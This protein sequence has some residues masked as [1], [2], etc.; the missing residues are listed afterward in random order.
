MVLR[1]ITNPDDKTDGAPVIC[2]KEKKEKGEDAHISTHRK[3]KKG[4]GSGHLSLLI[5]GGGSDRSANIIRQISLILI[6]GCLVLF[7][8]TSLHLAKTGLQLKK[9]I[10][11]AASAGFKNIVNGA[12]AIEGAKF[13][14]AKELFQEAGAIFKNMEYQTWF[15]SPGMATLELKDPI[16]D[17]ANALVGTGRYLASAGETF[18]EVAQNLKSIPKNIFEANNKFYDSKTPHPSLTDELKKELPMLLLCAQDLENANGQI[19]KIPDTFVPVNLRDQFNFAKNALSTL[20]DFLGSLQSDIPAILTLLGDKEP[21]TFLILL[22]NNAEL[23]PS[24]GFIGNYMIVETNDGYVTKMEVFDVYSA[25]HNLAE[26]IE[27]PAEILPANTRWFLRDSNYSGH[28]PLSAEKAAWFLEKEGGPGV[29]TVIAV[30]QTLI[31]ELLRLT[32]PIKVPELSQ[33]LTSNNFTTV[34]SYIVESK[35][36]GREDPKAILRSFLNSFEKNIFQNID[37]G[38]LPPLLQSVIGSKHLMAYSK[39][40]DVEAFFERHGVSGEMKKLESKEDY[41]NIVHTS[42]GGNK[43]DDYIAEVIGHDTYLELD[44]SVIDQ[45]SITRAHQ[46]DGKTTQ[47]IL[48]KLTPFGFTKVDNKVWQIFGRAHNIQFL[49]I[50]VPAG[51]VMEISS[52]PSV[53][54]QFDPETGKTYFSVKMRAEIGAS[55]TIKIRYRLPFKLNLDPVDKYYLTVQ[56]QAGQSNVSIKK[57][58]LPA[59]GVINYKYFPNNGA[60]DAE[61]IWTLETELLG[62]TSF[63]SIWGK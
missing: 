14:N 12:L 10:V 51:S 44:G 35:L 21:H 55:N 8:I 29:D 57:R 18:T 45:V 19:R 1:D 26:S 30:D 59:S 58:I 24:G 33:P 50:Y 46:W 7:A 37:P 41:L 48:D 43:S 42:I 13:E 63:S 15:T 32:G 60:F 53:T 27:P 47:L 23:R 39:N 16:F 31:T 38:A 34:V 62:D 22:Q 17:S 3:A 2:L 40:P 6:A 20:T 36:S 61:G 52:D 54:T 28:F 4:P 56:K 11:E 49:R 5:K 25:D 9:N